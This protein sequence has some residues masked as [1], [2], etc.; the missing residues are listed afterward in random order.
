MQR[1]Y[2]AAVVGLLVVCAFLL[3]TIVSISG[4]QDA[5]AGTAMSAGSV[6]AVTGAVGSGI[7]MLYVIDG[8]KKQMAVYT[9]FGGKL[10]FVAARRIRYDLELKAMNDETP[11]GASVDVL[12]ELWRRDQGEK[13]DGDGQPP[14]RK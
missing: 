4:A 11:R 10:K 8:E 7:D 5:N 9:A 1:T 6:L 14:K 3:G 2:Q 12:H 13:P